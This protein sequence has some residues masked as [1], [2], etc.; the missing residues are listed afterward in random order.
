MNLVSVAFFVFASLLFILYFIA[1][2]KMQWWILLVFSYFFYMFANPLLVV[3]LISVTM[4][5]YIAG[6]WMG[7]HYKA[8]EIFLEANR[9]NLTK[10]AKKQLKNQLKSK[11]LRL[12]MTCLVFNLGIL[13]FLKYSNFFIDLMNGLGLSV[14]HIGWIL[15]PIGLSFYTFQ[16]VGYA[17]DV[18]QGNIEAEKN[19][20]RYALFVSFFPQILEGPIG[21]YKELAPQ[22]VAKHPFDY[23]QFTYGLQ[24]ALWGV[25]K[26]I[27]IANRIAL[28]VQLIYSN[29]SDYSGFI[30]TLATFMYA[31]QLYAD[32]SGYMDI[33]LGISQALGIRLTENFQRPYF[34]RSI[35]EFWRR[36]HITLGAWFR[37]FLFYPLMRSRLI[38]S[39]S[40]SAL[41]KKNK[42]LK[43]LPI[44]I[45]FVVLWTLIGFWHGAAWTFIL[46]GLYHG[47]LIILEMITESLGIRMRTFF[48]IND[49]K[50]IYKGFQMARTFLLVC[51][52]YVLFRSGT[53]EQAVSIYH[54]IF[55][56]FFHGPNGMLDGLFTETFR[57][58]E[59]FVSFVSALIFLVV[60]IV[61]E[62]T[63]VREW[64]SKK[65]W[66][67]RW[68]IY[69]GL[70]FL[71]IFWG[72]Y[73]PGYN[74]SDFIY[75]QF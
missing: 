36:W 58:R 64:V 1:P 13:G 3:V 2:K 73:G 62:K 61:Q 4:S 63:S 41:V 53:L 38:T 52:A 31:I 8:Y 42:F 6:R 47:T 37:D 24:R 69:Q 35:T 11:N 20:A 27:V 14:S 74:A 28:F 59:W 72:M 48:H 21:R 23:V 26:K 12:L 70:I 45:T 25:F 22:L 60:S 71:T 30:L 19:I 46:Y 65:G 15:L 66:V 43:D 10:D 39:V 7:K 29:S 55:F 57:K 49:Q 44:V 68:A 33:A 32:F 5:T 75:M 40:K 54:Q 51:L 17:I 56:S 67:I 16:S 9:E 50:V 18:Y 34:S